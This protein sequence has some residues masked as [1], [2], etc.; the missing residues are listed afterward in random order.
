MIDAME[1]IVNLVGWKDPVE[2]KRRGNPR[3][4]GKRQ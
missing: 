1:R 3:R 4:N 2:K